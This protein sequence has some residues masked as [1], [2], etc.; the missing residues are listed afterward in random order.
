MSFG[1][2]LCFDPGIAVDHCDF[3]ALPSSQCGHAPLLIPLVFRSGLEVIQ[4]E[5]A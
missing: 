1:K 3:L 4:L 5:V 2:W